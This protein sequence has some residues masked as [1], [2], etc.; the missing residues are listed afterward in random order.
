MANEIKVRCYNC[1]EEFPEDEIIY[2]GD[3]DIDFYTNIECF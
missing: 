2:D 1:M 3:L